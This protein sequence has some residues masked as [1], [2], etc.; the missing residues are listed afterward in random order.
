[1]FNTTGQIDY[2]LQRI[3]GQTQYIS[4]NAM[5]INLAGLK[6]EETNVLPHF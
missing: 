5:G 3:F 4:E 1:M 2:A 6:Q